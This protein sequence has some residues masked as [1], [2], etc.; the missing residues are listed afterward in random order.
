MREFAEKFYKSKAW[1]KC[2]KAYL[3][4]QGGLCERCRAKGLIVPAEIVH[5]REHI[6]PETISDPNVL[7][8][9][10]NLQC[11]CRQCHAELHGAQGARRFTVAPDGTVIPLCDD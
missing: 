6:T 11:V 1:Q 7:L 5:H 9:W 10:S 8:N 4:S 3:K 2:R